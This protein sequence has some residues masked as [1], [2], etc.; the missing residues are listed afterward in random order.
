MFGQMKDK[1]LQQ[2]LDPSKTF[3]VFLLRT[4]N[5]VLICYRI[6]VIISVVLVKRVEDADGSEGNGDVN[7]GSSFTFFVSCKEKAGIQ[8]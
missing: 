6:F 8:C 4:P 1:L 2:A 3:K 5:F 7:K